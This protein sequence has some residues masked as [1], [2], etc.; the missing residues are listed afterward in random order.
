MSGGDYIGHSSV[1]EK[2]THSSIHCIWS[3]V[4]IILVEWYFT[5]VVSSSQW[6]YN[7]VRIYENS[8][9]CFDGEGFRGDRVIV[10]FLY[11]VYIIYYD[12]MREVWIS[13]CHNYSCILSVVFRGAYCVAYNE[14]FHVLFLQSSF[15]KKIK[16][17]HVALGIICLFT[18]M[19][20]NYYKI[21]IGPKLF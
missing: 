6:F 11:N 17:M 2:Y 14:V 12:I 10:I 1:Y 7:N 13:K 4:W 21:R 3:K 9:L 5:I 18:I 19:V 16:L 20:I 15:A 8:L